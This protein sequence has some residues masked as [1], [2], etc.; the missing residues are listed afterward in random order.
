VFGCKHAPMALSPDVEQALVAAYGESHRAYHTAAHIAELLRWFDIVAE[1]PGW[2]RPTD[3]YLAILFHDAVYDATRTDN[4]QRSADLAHRLA[5]ASD[6]AVEL[7]EL[8]AKH[9]RLHRTDVNDVDAMHFL[10]A[11]TA[12]LGADAAAFDAYDAAIAVEYRHVPADAFRA[13]R[14][15]FLEKM[16]A[17]ERIYFSDYFHDKLDAKARAN[18]ARAIAKLS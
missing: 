1:G 14:R 5:H 9:G 6:H 16:L 8:T 13:G 10:D 18:L 11:D 15:A 4:E 7:I 3:V 2:V 17:R 12:I